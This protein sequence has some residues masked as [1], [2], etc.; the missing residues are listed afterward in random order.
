MAPA[1]CAT[2]SQIKKD[3][4]MGKFNQDFCT[5]GRIT[6]LSAILL[7]VGFTCGAA[8]NHQFE[9]KT[10]SA[11]FQ[12]LGDVPKGALV[13]G[14]YSV[15]VEP[16]HSLL[17]YVEA[18]EEFPSTKKIFITDTTSC[19]F[20]Y[21]PKSQYG[22]PITTIMTGSE[23]GGQSWTDVGLKGRFL[24]RG[25]KGKP[26]VLLNGLWIEEPHI[27]KGIL[28]YDGAKFHYDQVSGG[29]DQEANLSGT[30]P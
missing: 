14:V 27:S 16:N 25:I 26:Q 15:E 2:L 13:T 9:K 29:W 24:L 1:P 17:L 12:H 19:S 22:V 20:S 4:A 30:Q 11:F 21:S 23:D 18:D 6:I 8:I 5:L 10:I 7:V 3:L 28:D